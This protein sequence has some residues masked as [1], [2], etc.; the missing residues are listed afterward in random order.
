MSYRKFEIWEI[1]RE[2]VVKI[3]KMTIRDL[4]KYEMYE[5]GSQIS[6]EKIKL[7]YKSHL[8]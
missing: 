6:G 7:I 3:H 2:L 5:E 4:P 8:Q 1:A